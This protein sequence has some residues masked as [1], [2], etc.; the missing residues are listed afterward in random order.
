MEIKLLTVLAPRTHIELNCEHATFHRKALSVPVGTQVLADE[1][2]IIP[3]PRKIPFWD[4]FMG[5]PLECLLE[6]RVTLSLEKEW[7]E[8]WMNLQYF[9][10]HR[11][12]PSSNWKILE[13]VYTEKG[14]EEVFRTMRNFEKSSKFGL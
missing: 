7:F 12:Y 14:C 4:F 3:P 11:T 10:E 9:V 1:M 8:R 5:V 13:K 6:V 2:R